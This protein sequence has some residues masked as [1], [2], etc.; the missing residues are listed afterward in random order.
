MFILRGDTHFSAIFKLQTKF[1]WQ[2][3]WTRVGKKVDIG[4]SCKQTNSSWFKPTNA[5]LSIVISLFDSLLKNSGFYDSKEIFDKVIRKSVNLMIKD[6]SDNYLN[7]FVD[8]VKFIEFYRKNRY[9]KMGFLLKLS[10][11]F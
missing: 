7:Q 6:N 4:F 1:V 9:F 5:F 8:K 10:F 11:F 3:D 2:R